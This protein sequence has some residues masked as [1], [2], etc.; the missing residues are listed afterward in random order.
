MDCAHVF[1]FLNSSISASSSRCASDRRS[2]FAKKGED[3]KATEGPHCAVSAVLPL[4]SQT[5]ALFVK[6]A[7]ALSARKLAAVVVVG[8]AIRIWLVISAQGLN[9]DGYQ[10]A[11]ITRQMADHGVLEGLRGD[12]FWPYLPVNTRLVVYPFL[13]SLVYRVVGDAVIS[14]RLVSAFFGT[15]LIVLTFAVAKEAF[16]NERVA[17]ISA[18]LVGVEPEFARAS[19]SVYRETTAA[20]MV[21]LAFYLLLRTVRQKRLWPAGAASVGVA[22]FAGWLTRPELALLVGTFCIGTLL[23]SEL[24]RSKRIMIPIIMCFSFA[25]LELPYFL[26]LRET[27]ELTTFSQWQVQFEYPQEHAVERFLQLRKDP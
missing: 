20:F 17:L 10:F 8:A 24:S 25:V 1:R 16:G 14:L 23:F 3:L 15:A 5:V 7:Q 21:L 2:R 11:L 18:L 27:T 13:G 4:R 9:S 12:Y 19:A 6:A 26:W 22:F